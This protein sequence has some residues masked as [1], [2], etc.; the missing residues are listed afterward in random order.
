MMTNV[1]VID[2]VFRF[3][4]G[5][6]LLALSDGR[7]WLHP[8]HELAWAAW[9]AGAFFSFTGLFRYCPA[10][11]LAGTDS[12]AIYPAPPPPPSNTLDKGHPSA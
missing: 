7:L 3:V 2:G 1:G 11:A 12:C 5:V 10:Y 9:I 8:P 4:L 6:G